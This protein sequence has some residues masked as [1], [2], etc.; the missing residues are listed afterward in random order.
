MDAQKL[1]E[2]LQAD[3]KKNPNDIAVVL[4]SL[5]TLI[6]EKVQ[7]GTPVEFGELG[8]FVQ[9]E[10]GKLSFEV[11][12]EF[13][14]LVNYKYETIQPVPI[15]ESLETYAATPDSQEG[16]EEISEEI[17]FDSEESPFVEAP[18]EINETPDDLVQDV[19]LMEPETIGF[20]EEPAPDLSEPEPVT[21]DEP[22]SPEPTPADPKPADVFPEPTLVVPEET[23]ASVMPG[24][25]EPEPI[26]EPPAPAFI[27][28]AAPIPA[29]APVADT[30]GPIRPPGWHEPADEPKPAGPKPFQVPSEPASEEHKKIDPTEYVL[31]PTELGSEMDHKKLWGF[32]ALGILLLVAAIWY[33]MSGDTAKKKELLN[34]TADSVAASQQVPAK[35]PAPSVQDLATAPVKKA[36][37]PKKT[38]EPVKPA[39]KPVAKSETKQP[40]SQPVKDSKVKESAPAAKTATAPAEKPAVKKPAAITE[41]EPAIHSGFQTPVDLA[42]GGFTIN[43]GSLPT[44]AAA[45]KLLGKWKAMGYEGV[46]QPADVNG[47]QVFRVRLGQFTSRAKALAGLEELKADIPDAWVDRLK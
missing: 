45:G 11:N 8:E 23:V 30:G 21:W 25:P 16:Q 38:T 29:P 14:R 4:D 47:K 20:A 9:S 7:S 28:P 35:T 6:L 26:P 24:E 12:A 37:E 36:E 31:S 41:D 18:A 34:T 10:Y 46:V 40:A 19:P 13:A 2:Q 44:E 3:T 32:I 39:E 27:P 42:K 15:D 22:V 1:F 5:I 43:I 17:S 33:F